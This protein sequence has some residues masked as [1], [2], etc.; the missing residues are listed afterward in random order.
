MN[1]PT[2]NH[3]ILKI[4]PANINADGSRKYKSPLTYQHPYSSMEDY[5]K[6]LSLKYDAPRTQ[7]S[8]YR[9]LRLLQ[10]FFDQDPL[11]FDENDIRDYFLFVKNKKKW[12]PKTI[13]QSAAA[14]RLFYDN[15]PD[16]EDWTVFSQIR[17]KDHD[18]LPAV[19][20]R[21]QV[22]AVIS[23]IRLRRYRIPFKLMYCCGLRLSECL[24]LTIHDIRG[25]ENK[26]WIRQSKN[27]Q[28]RMVPISD[29]MVGDLR[30]YW[31][32]HQNPLLLFPHAGRGDQSS[33]ATSGPQNSYPAPLVRDAFY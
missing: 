16:S 30:I 28:D 10:E 29:V 21:E 9:Q 31:K 11:Y 17:T 26:L 27:H 7:C 18:E 25:S 5:A 22:R 14:I 19:L 12:K 13:R 20:T 15:Y 23:Q 33:E 6:Q 2:Q 32:T 1:H 8:Y 24:S 4:D 3:E